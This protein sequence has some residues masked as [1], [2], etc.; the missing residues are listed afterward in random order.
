MPPQGLVPLGL[1]DMIERTGPQVTAPAVAVGH[2]IV[3]IAEALIDRVGIDRC[4]GEDGT[5]TVAFQIA[6]LHEAV[7]GPAERLQGRTAPGQ[8]AVGPEVGLRYV[9][10]PVLSQLRGQECRFGGIGYRMRFGVPVGF[11]LLHIIG[12][13]RHDPGELGIAPPSGQPGRGLLDDDPVALRIGSAGS[14]IA[15]GDP[16]GG[17]GGCRDSR[18]GQPHNCDLE[19]IPQVGHEGNL[20]TEPEI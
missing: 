15:K 5:I 2:D 20:P 13:V 11:Q 17:D 14:F 16:A 3:A 6:P 1:V 7:L 19:D 18:Q 8:R 10:A 12:I 4:N 9:S